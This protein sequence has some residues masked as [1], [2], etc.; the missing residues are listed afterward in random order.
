MFTCH[1]LYYEGIVFIDSVSRE[2]KKWM[3]TNKYE[4]DNHEKHVVVD[5]GHTCCH[6]FVYTARRSE[7]LFQ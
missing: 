7:S 4:D 2:R 3:Q 6:F 5:F 1:F